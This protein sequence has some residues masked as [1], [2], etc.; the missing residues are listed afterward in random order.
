MMGREGFDV[1][2]S[3]GQRLT[4]KLYDFQKG[5]E[6]DYFN[7]GFMTWK[8][9]RKTDCFLRNWIASVVPTRVWD[10][11]WFVDLM[12]SAREAGHYGCEQFY[13][14][15][16]FLGFPARLRLRIYSQFE[17]MHRSLWEDP[18]RTAWEGVRRNMTEPYVLHLPGWGKAEQLTRGKFWCFNSSGC[19]ARSAGKNM[20]IETW[21]HPALRRF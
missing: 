17:V 11:Q 19:H 9:N 18:E 4:R 12:S 2:I 15:S 8:G 7:I 16:D 3:T 20:F 14:L 1:E 10:Q 21:A 6:F 5:Y 13:N